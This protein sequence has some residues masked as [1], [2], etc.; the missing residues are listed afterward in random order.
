MA[1]TPSVQSDCGSRLV[2]ARSCRPFH[3]RFVGDGGSKDKVWRG[4]LGRRTAP[5]YD[6]Q[7][8]DDA[9]QAILATVVP[10]YL[11]RPGLV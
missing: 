11:H 7:G 8:S 4:S 3:Q 2:L 1:A 6:F 9:T 10:L 5:R